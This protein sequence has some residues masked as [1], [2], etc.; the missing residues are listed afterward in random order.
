MLSFSIPVA[1][2]RG[3]CGTNK[4]AFNTLF[5]SESCLNRVGWGVQLSGRG[6]VQYVSQAHKL[7][8][9][10]RLKIGQNIGVTHGR[11]GYKYKLHFR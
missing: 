1:E 5:R 3:G 11:G 8:K 10:K 9:E 2:N 6:Q 4:A 7:V